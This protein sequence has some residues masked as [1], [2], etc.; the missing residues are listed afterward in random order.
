THQ[1]LRQR[2]HTVGEAGPSLA[3][4]RMKPIVEPALEELGPVGPPA[5]ERARHLP[6]RDREERIRLAIPAG[7]VHRVTRQRPAP[8]NRPAAAFGDSS[9]PVGRAVFDQVPNLLTDDPVARRLLAPGFVELPDQPVP[10]A[11]DVDRLGRQGGVTLV[12]PIAI[13]TDS[14]IATPART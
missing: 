11:L 2:E 14:L 4:E 8:P 10:R 1:G 13:A 9:G 7:R 3:V 6:G 12:V 5:I